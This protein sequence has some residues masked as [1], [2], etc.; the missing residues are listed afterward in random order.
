MLTT[1]ATLAGLALA[2]QTDTTV[3][4]REGARLEVNNFGGEIAVK[5]WS[6]SAV[7]IAASHSS[8]DR[9]TIDASEQ[10]VRGKSAGRR[11]PSQV[12]AHELTVPAAS[13]LALPA[14]Y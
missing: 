3:P 5:T 12:V 11:G 13:A 14:G 9:I 10:V 7:R 4:V 2:Q 8:R 6:K 1:L